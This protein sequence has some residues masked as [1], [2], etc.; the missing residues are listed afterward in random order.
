MNP[1]E[2]INSLLVG[3]FLEALPLAVGMVLGIYLMRRTSLWAGQNSLTAEQA[4]RLIQRLFQWTSAVVGDVDACRQQME[5][6]DRSAQLVQETDSPPPTYVDL[7][8]KM[9]QANRQMQQKLAVAEDALGEQA[10]K[11]AACL[12]EARTDALTKL[13]NRRWF[14]EE[15]A[16]R[17]AQ[18]KRYGT[19]LTVL[20]LDI[21][22]F[23]RCN[24]THGHLVGDDVLGRVAQ[25][26]G[27]TLRE[28]D[29][30]ARFGGEEFAALLTSTDMQ[31]SLAVAERARQAVAA[32][33]TDNNGTPVRVTVSCGLAEPL[34]GE[35]PRELLQRTDEALYASKEGGRDCGHWHD[36]VQCQ[37]IASPE[38]PVSHVT[39]ENQLE[40]ARS[41]LRQRLLEVTADNSR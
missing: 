35:K 23:K 29:M 4:E 2:P 5:A 15:L 36:G 24:D 17:H 18:W 9:V 19:G 1:W 6:I 16:R 27:Q 33:T 37:P 3:A 26:I 7:M 32:L 40:L 11:I 30:L 39:P 8:A 28:T 12:N 31:D 38:T 13:P 34:E 25:A 20:L 41:A 21:D 14:D 10:E 22:H